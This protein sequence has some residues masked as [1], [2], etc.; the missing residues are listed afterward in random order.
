MGVTNGLDELI[1]SWTRHELNLSAKALDVVQGY[2]S[3][4]VAREFD[5]ILSDLSFKSLDGNY[6][7]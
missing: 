1:N 5:R 7:A 3:E 2:S 4:A 6:V